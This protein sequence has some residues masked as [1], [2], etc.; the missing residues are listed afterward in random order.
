VRTIA[1]ADAIMSLDNVVAVAAAARNSVPLI[2]FGIAVSVPL[3]IFG[4]TLM[5]SLFNRF[6]FLITA[7]AAL[8][9]WVAGGIMVSDPALTAWFNALPEALEIWA[10]LAGVALMLLTAGALRW[11]RSHQPAA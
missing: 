7:G 11:S 6:P 4:S 5:L 3:I 9:G 8:L 2:I 10:G 1:L